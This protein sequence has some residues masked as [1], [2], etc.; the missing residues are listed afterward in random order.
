MPASLVRCPH[1]G[2][3]NRVPATAAGTPRC[4][5][6]HRPLPWIVD[7]G[8]EDFAEVAERAPVPVLIDLWAPWCGP[9]RMVSPALEQLA[10][11]RAGRLK[12]VK[13]NVDESPKLQQRFGVQA[14]PTLMVLRD[15]QVAARQAG[16]APAPALRAWLEQTLH[17]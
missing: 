13:V 15:G 12:L 9:C 16:A 7:G 6:C 5:N 4:G 3:R 1:C 8:D 2:R 14:I 17:S 10:T 11:E